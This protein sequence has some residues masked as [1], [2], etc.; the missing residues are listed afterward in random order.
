VLK[1]VEAVRREGRNNLL[2]TESLEILRLYGLRLP[3]TAFARSPGE[4]AVEARKLGFPVAIKIVSP[5]ILH[6]SDVGGVK[7]NLA[8]AT[9]VKNSARAVLKQIAVERSTARIDGFL[10][11]P[12]APPGQEC[13]FGVFRDPGF[14]PVIM[15]GLGGIFVE[16]LKDVAFG[17]TP[18][19]ASDVD[20]MIRSIRGYRLLTGFRGEG[21]KDIEAV[22]RLIE[23]LSLI[24]IENPDLAE[25]DLNPVIVH[26]HGSSV[27]DARIILTE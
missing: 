13:I 11:S 4:A 16:A 21:E 15:F 23:R 10:V 12:M 7:L 17:V 24:A 22:R 19:S 14:G 6:K 1:I 18:L 5:D 26:S 25:L 8:S 27:V 3:P 2:E 20:R 9:A